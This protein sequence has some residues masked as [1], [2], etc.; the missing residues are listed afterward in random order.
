MVCRQSPININTKNCYSLH[1][2]DIFKTDLFNKNIIS[3]TEIINNNL[4]YQVQ[5][6]LF[7]FFNG[8]NFKLEQYHFHYDSEHKINNKKFDM[9]CHFVHRHENHY[10][11]LGFFLI[12]GD[13]SPFDQSL[14][15]NKD[16]YILKFKYTDKSFYY[17]PGSLTTKPFSSNVSWLLF[18]NPIKTNAIEKWN[19]KYGKARPIQNNSGSEVFKF[20][21]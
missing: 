4:I 3:K 9:E 7:T 5:N 15:A 20:I 14:N 19:K 11:V 10:L 12:K 18:D 2:P 13:E 16:E 17:Y 8:Y 1:S 6:D 21:F